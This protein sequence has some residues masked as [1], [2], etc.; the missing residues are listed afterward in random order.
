MNAPVL[1]RTIAWFCLAVALLLSVAPRQS[2]VLCIETDGCL[3]VAPSLVSEHCDGCEPHERELART[4]DAAHELALA[5]AYSLAPATEE[6][7]P[8]LDVEVPG[9]PEAKRSEPRTGAELASL[10]L[11]IAARVPGHELVLAPP[12]ERELP[13]AAPPRPRESLAH[14]AS[15]V[16]LV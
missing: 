3:S 14:V 9:A 2:F 8:C 6:P 4:A 7:C 12:R 1:R 16:L 11:D 15:V 13:P 5:A 10:A